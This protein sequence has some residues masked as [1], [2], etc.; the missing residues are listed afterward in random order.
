MCYFMTFTCAT[1]LNTIGPTKSDP[2][3]IWKRNYGWQ[4]VA[5]DETLLLRHLQHPQTNYKA[6]LLIIIGYISI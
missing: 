4:I 1:L 3:V 2:C 6:M 5:P